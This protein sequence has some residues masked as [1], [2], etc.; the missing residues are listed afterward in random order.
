LLRIGHRIGAVGADDR[1]LGAD[2]ARILKI[3]AQVSC[4]TAMDVLAYSI[5]AVVDA[6]DDIEVIDLIKQHFPDYELRFVEE[7]PDDWK[8][9]SRFR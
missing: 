7:K 2:E 5:C 4:E 3:L 6:Q 9:V 8:P 1:S